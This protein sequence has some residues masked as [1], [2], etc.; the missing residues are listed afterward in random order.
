MA[1]SAPMIEPEKTALLVMDYQQGIVAMLPE[2]GLILERMHGAIAAA[3]ACNVKIGYVRVAFTDADYDA[4][5][6]TNKAFAAL[7]GSGRRMHDEAAET[8]IHERVKPQPDDI[9]VRK[10]R[11]GALS[12]TDLDAQLRA[13]GIDTLILAGISTSGVVLS[14][15]RDAADRDYRLY[16]LT[17]ACADLDRT[18]HD[19]LT[20]SVFPRQA[21]T[22]STDELANLL[23]RP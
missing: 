3:R 16:V 15:L 17:D 4:V 10:T 18:V 9:I 5:P 12:T 8:A 6:E 13:R 1:K 22:I 11:V 7:A 14:T 23:I 21:Y 19:T 20:Q 2:P